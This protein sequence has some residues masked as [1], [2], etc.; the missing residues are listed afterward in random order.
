[1]EFY[2]RPKYMASKAR[3]ALLNP[4]ELPRLVKSGQ[5]FFKYLFKGSQ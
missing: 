2:L 3:Q 5:T 1:M 4:K